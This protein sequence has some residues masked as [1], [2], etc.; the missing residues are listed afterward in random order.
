MNKQLG[1]FYT[2]DF[3]IIKR[4]AEK[5]SSKEVIDPFAGQGDLLFKDNVVGYDIDPKNQRIE[6]R[7]TLTNPLNY[8]NK[9]VITNPPFLAKNKSVDKTIFNKYGVDD[10]YKA[11]LES[12]MT[13]EEGAII[14]PINFFSSTRGEQ[15]RVNFLSNFIVEEVD[16]FEQR[17]FKDTDY[18]VCSFYFKKSKNKVNSQ[19]ITFNFKPSNE[20]RALTLNKENDFF[21]GVKPKSIAKSSYKVSRL[22][23]DSDDGF[24]TNIKIYAI[25]GTKEESK[26]R[27]TIEEPFYGKNS[28]RTY[29]T[30][31]LDREISLEKQERIV[32]EFNKK[33]EEYRNKY[34][35]LC[36]SNYRN[37][38]EFGGRKRISFSLAYAFIHEILNGLEEN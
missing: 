32:K 30:I 25:D 13:C 19:I 26:I 4:F 35:G 10:L 22:T 12:I 7:D 31:V 18:L 17:V 11:S 14:L 2:D 29:A 38:G 24:I 8:A 28:D 36:Y 37:S 16:V 23:K 20:T 5:I 27:A 34:M 21:I 9:A 15:T 3:S 1:Q 6:V 33:V